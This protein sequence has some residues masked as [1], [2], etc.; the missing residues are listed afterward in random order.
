MRKK[1][2][3][4]KEAIKTQGKREKKKGKRETKKTAPKQQNGSK[5]KTIKNYLKCKGSKFSNQKTEW[6]N[7]LKN[8]THLYVA[9]KRLTLEVRTH[10]CTLKVKGWR[11]LYHASGSEKKDSIAILISEKIDFKTNTVLKFSHYIM[12]KESSQ[13]IQHLQIYVHHT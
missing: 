6:L 3:T 9:S 13:K 1:T 4:P 5:Y 12:R 8:M 2:I 7:G 10:T 11:N